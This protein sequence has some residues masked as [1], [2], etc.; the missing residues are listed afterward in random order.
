MNTSKGFIE[1]PLTMVQRDYVEKYGDNETNLAITLW[2]VYSYELAYLIAKDV[3]VKI[4]D[5][6]PYWDTTKAITLNMKFDEDSIL[7]STPERLKDLRASKPMMSFVWESSYG[8]YITFGVFDEYCYRVFRTMEF[9]LAFMLT[10]PSHDSIVV[11]Y[12]T[13]VEAYQ[14]AVSE[15]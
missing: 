9:P 7:K 1:N 15:K 6:F 10:R 12:S 14:K 4:P 5:K 3:K 2:S 13:I 11:K 8:E